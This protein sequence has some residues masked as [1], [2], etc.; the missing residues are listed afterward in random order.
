MRTTDVDTIE[1]TMPARPE[2]LVLARLHA[3][4]AGG[5]LDLNVDEIDDLRLAVEEL[6][7][8]ALDQCVS[9]KERLRV[10]LSWCG[11]TLEA[12]SRLLGDGG[13]PMP[14]DAHAADP[15]AL[16]QRILDALVDEHGLTEEDGSWA[17]WF[18]KRLPTT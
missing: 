16:S 18:R 17:A 13:A 8:W 2:L 12:S 14:T 4:T 15:S 7:L 5:L 11:D 10:V 6:C 9:K 3:G 1:L